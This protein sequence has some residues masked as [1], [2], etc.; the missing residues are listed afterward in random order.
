MNANNSEKDRVQED[1]YCRAVYLSERRRHLFM[2]LFYLL[3]F[4]VLILILYLV[5][6]F[7]FIQSLILSG[8]C[9]EMTRRF[10]HLSS[11]IKFKKFRLTIVPNWSKI[12]YDNDYIKGNIRDFF[13]KHTSERP[14]EE[15][16]ITFLQADLWYI[17]HL[18]KFETAWPRSL[19]VPMYQNPFKD[20]P[21]FYIIPHGNMIEFGLGVHA[22][23]YK[24]LMG[25]EPEWL[26]PQ[27]QYAGILLARLPISFFINFYENYSFFNATTWGEKRIKNIIKALKDNE[28]QPPDLHLSGYRHNYI[29]LT[30]EYF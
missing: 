30:K 28:W 29:Y 3:Y 27:S 26:L 21:V 15:I 11:M 7:L 22:D 17:H 1:P 9:V 23:A 10:R 2:I 20:N 18:G 6:G 4:I 19:E 13:K 25:T 16:V 5:A 24:H 8:I 14:V 12:L